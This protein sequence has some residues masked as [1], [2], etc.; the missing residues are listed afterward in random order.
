[1]IA[2]DKGYR[3]VG[4]LKETDFQIFEIPSEKEKRQ[5]RLSAFQLIDPAVKT[6]AT[7]VSSGGYRVALSGGCAAGITVHYRLS[8]QPGA[9]GWKGGYHEI[10]VTTTR[11]GVTL[12]FRHTYYVG[13]NDEAAG[14]AVQ[15]E[16]QGLASLKR[17]ACFH[18]DIPPSMAMNGRLVDATPEGVMRYSMVIQPD[19]LAFSS[20]ADAQHR[21]ALDYGAC[22]FDSA[23]MAIQFMHHSTVAELSQADY[24]KV[25]VD[26]FPNNI[27]LP[28]RPEASM[29]RLV[30]RDRSTGNLGIMELSANADGRPLKKDKARND[31]SFKI[32]N[33][34]A[35]VVTH[36]VGSFGS[37]VPQSP[38]MCGDVYEVK[39]GT[40][41]IIT[42]FGEQDAVGRLYAPELDVHQQ[43]VTGGLPG[44]TPNEE[45]FSIDYYGEFGR[46][47]R[48]T[49]TSVFCRRRSQLVHRRPNGHRTGWN[50]SAHTGREDD[51]SG[52]GP[53]YASLALLPGARRGEFDPRGKGSGTIDGSNGY[54]E[55]WSAHGFTLTSGNGQRASAH[56]IDIMRGLLKEYIRG[57]DQSRYKTKPVS[58][59][60]SDLRWRS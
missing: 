5:R 6:A 37:V 25:V 2:R 38:A 33:G 41:K 20:I 43:R 55:V 17:A 22:V 39:P 11:P 52:C 15:S 49:I 29:V 36:A 18:G 26:G 42:N 9:D 54:A 27:D 48:A 45:W 46:W 8:F 13:Q 19:S 21:V 57:L 31:D 14:S 58:R 44:A 7:P 50:P 34:R 32:V 53:A 3:P 47:S 10:L 4:D 40:P 16:A 56:D 51:P 24:S 28:R 12:T 35:M 30:V 1:M 23:G 60:S 59:F